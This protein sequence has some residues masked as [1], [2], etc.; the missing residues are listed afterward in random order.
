MTHHR[1]MLADIENVPEIN[2]HASTD[3]E[4]G[5]KANHLA[6]KGAGKEKS[7]KAHPCPPLASELAGV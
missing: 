6:S 2:K 4:E 7:S 1:I 5:E 3:R